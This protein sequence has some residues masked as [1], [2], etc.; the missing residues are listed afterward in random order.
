MPS[1]HL[2]WDGV[3]GPDKKVAPCVDAGSY[4]IFDYRL[5]H[6]GPPIENL[7]LLTSH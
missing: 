2:D 4:I 3:D 1:S 6:R 5:R 7:S